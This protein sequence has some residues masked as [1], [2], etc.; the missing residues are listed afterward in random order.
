MK[1]VQGNNSNYTDL[2]FGVEAQVFLILIYSISCFL[3]LFG[4]LIVI[5][6]LNFGSQSKADVNIYLTVIA[7]A[8]IAMAVFCIPFTFTQVMLGKWIFYDILCP[9][10]R[11]MQVF[12]VAVSIF[13]TVALGID[14]SVLT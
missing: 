13:T 3:S 2:S 10:S 6:V 1:M 14:R 8:D 4:N 11:S 12:S 5:L 9:L 7:L